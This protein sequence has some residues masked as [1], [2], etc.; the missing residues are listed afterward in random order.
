LR[1]YL[2]SNLPENRD[3]DFY[4]RDFQAKNNNE[5]ADILGNF[6]NRTLT[7]SQKHFNSEV[8]EVK[9][10]SEI[11]SKM[12]TALTEYVDKVGL[13]YERIKIK[14]ALTEIMNLA[15]AANKFFNDSEPWKSVKSDKDKCA[16]TIF[17]SLQVIRTLAIMI[18]PIIP[19]TSVRVYSILNLN[20]N[21]LKMWNNA[22]AAL[23]STGH[24]I[25]AP[26][27]IVK[28]IEDKEI[29][30]FL[31]KEEKEKGNEIS[32]DEFKRVEIRVAK[33]LS[34]E[35]V[36]KSKKLL[37]LKVDIGSEHRQVIAGL[38]E[39]YE[40]K[41]LIDKRVL[42]VSNLQK[43]TLM[44][45]TSE[46]MVLA[47]EDNDKKLKLVEVPESLPLGAVLR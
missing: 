2:A 19:A 29:L 8:P 21:E 13:L 17:V 10:L 41:D 18:S 31:P 32:I 4:W 1:Y 42:I 11:D 7:F 33:V 9:N 15:R 44:N 16:A 40:A 37:K 14:D 6:I 35:K 27:I 20:N 46:G 30:P 5:L 28:K 22:A 45:E 3:T 43:A 38:A 39:F 36:I 25:N 12:L 47:V 24:K 26:E 34:C 23:L